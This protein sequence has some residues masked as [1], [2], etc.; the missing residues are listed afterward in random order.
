MTKAVRVKTHQSYVLFSF[1]SYLCFTVETGKSQ[2]KVNCETQGI[3]L[4]TAHVCFRLEKKHVI[5]A[6]TS[7]IIIYHIKIIFYAFLCVGRHSVGKTGTAL[8]YYILK[9]LKNF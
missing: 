4:P 5:F 8:Y 7:I 3:P 9:L 2:S 1:S 6:R